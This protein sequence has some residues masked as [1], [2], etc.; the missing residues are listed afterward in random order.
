MKKLSKK[1]SYFVM[2][3]QLL[4]EKNSKP[5]LNEENRKKFYEKFKKEWKQEP[6]ETKQEVKVKKVY[7][8]KSKLKTNTSLSQATKPN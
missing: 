4:H 8:R 5:S 7:K 1:E 3:L 6:K 2:D